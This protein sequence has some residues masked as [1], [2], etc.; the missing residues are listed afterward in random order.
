MSEVSGELPPLSLEQWLPLNQAIIVEQIVQRVRAAL[1]EYQQLDLS[2]LQQAAT[3]FYPIWCTSVLHEDVD[4]Q[5]NY[6]SPIIERRL[7]QGFVTDD[8][9]RI[10]WMVCD[11]VIEQLQKQGDHIPQAERTAFAEKARDFTEKLGRIARLRI[12]NQ[13]MK[14]ITDDLKKPPR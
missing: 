8:L 5:L 10:P 11:A 9:S 2:E 4:L 12:I 7:R 3:A 13:V 6:V 14:R 1:P